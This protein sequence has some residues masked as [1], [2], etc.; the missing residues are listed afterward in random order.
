MAEPTTVPAPP[1]LNPSN[2][3]NV[4]TPITGR[5]IRAGYYDK[6]MVIYLQGAPN[7][8]ADDY[9]YGQ[10]HS[11]A[12]NIE[13][14]NDPMYDAM[15]EQQRTLVNEDERVKAVQDIQ[16]DLAEKLYAVS[17]VRSYFWELVQPL[18]R[19]YSYS[20]SIGVYTETYAK[21]WLDT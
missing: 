12:A 5:G 18:V 21:A 3:T 19:N 20:D 17:T 10:L 11:K 1:L 14:L 2:L 7:T 6:D 4:A 13:H 16:K 8:E 9:L 15:V